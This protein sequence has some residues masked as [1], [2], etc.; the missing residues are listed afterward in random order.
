[1]NDAPR[2][3]HAKFAALIVAGAIMGLSCASYTIQRQ[4][5]RKYPRLRRPEQIECFKGPLPDRPHNVLA[6]IDSDSATS[7]TAE[8]RMKQLAQLKKAASRAGAEAIYETR[9]LT[10]QIRG[11]IRDPYTP[12][13]SPTQGWRDEYFLR[14][15][16]V[17]YEEDRPTGGLRNAPAKPQDE[18]MSYAERIYKGE[19]LP[20]PKWK[21]YFLPK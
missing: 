15:A 13:P 4:T 11:L 20:R 10:R 17:I 1:M 9:M 18:S 6:N 19:P 16:A 8:T 5:R 2:F 7:S 3:H 12:F 14:G 21:R